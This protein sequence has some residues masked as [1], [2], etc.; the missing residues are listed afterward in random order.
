MII[1]QLTSRN[2][3]SVIEEVE[4]PD[5]VITSPMVNEERDKRLALG[6]SINVEGHPTPVRIEG[7]DKDIRNLQGL[8]L[9]AQMRM[10]MGNPD[11]LTTYRDADNLEHTLTQG[12]IADLFVKAMTHV[13]E[14][15]KASW[16]VKGNPKVPHDFRNPKHWP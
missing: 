1:K 15:Y 14:V 7:G 3:K 13:E 16:R 4:V 12:Q 10:T 6:T 5:L 2:G 11:A 9:G 8:A